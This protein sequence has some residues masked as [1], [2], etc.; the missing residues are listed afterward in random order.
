[1][2]RDGIAVTRHINDV[3][4][5]AI[6]KENQLLCSARGAR[7][8]RKVFSAAQCVDKARFAD[9]GSPG[10]GDFDAPHRWQR[11]WRA[12]RSNKL[13]VPGEQAPASFDFCTGEVARCHCRTARHYF[14]T[15]KTLQT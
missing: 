7:D 2:S 6:A 3:E 1:F 8:A 9:I 13:P 4:C 11:G 12:G 10:E 14:S 15:E 5:L